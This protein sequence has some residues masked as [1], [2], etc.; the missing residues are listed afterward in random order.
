MGFHPCLCVQKRAVINSCLT[1]AVIKYLLAFGSR[2]QWGKKNK[3][4]PERGF[5][6]V[7]LIVVAIAPYCTS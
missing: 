3:T 2:I 6:L 1:G 7:L 4:P 5:V